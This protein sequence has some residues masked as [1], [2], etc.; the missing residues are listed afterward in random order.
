[1]ELEEYK[2]RALQRLNKS[3]AFDSKES[4]YYAC[5]GLIEETG[6][7]I[8]ELRKPLFKGNFHEK[9]LDTKEIESELGD[10]MWY[11]SLI[12]KNEKIDMNKLQQ[13]QSRKGKE[14][15]KREKL[16][17]ISIK[18]GQYSGQ[19]VEQYKKNYMQKSDKQ[20]L[21]QKIEKQY[22]NILELSKELGLNL[23][24]ILEKNIIK[25]ESRYNEKGES[26]RSE[27][28]EK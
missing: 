26:T 8:A 2:K 25:I 21:I 13:Y 24:T 12:C 11:I 20:K 28:N 3:I 16:I 27:E 10:L 4:M 5:M 7:I 17:Q 18:M 15:S 19:I 14:L 6:E 23:E 9:A 1:M 22:N